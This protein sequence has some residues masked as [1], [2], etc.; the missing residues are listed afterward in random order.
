MLANPFLNTKNPPVFDRWVLLPIYQAPARSILIGS[1]GDIYD[2]RELHRLFE[3]HFEDWLT[4]LFVA[5]V[6]DII[7]DL[8]DELL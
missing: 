5:E 8:R 3:M 4:A 6:D 1:T 7:R 2:A